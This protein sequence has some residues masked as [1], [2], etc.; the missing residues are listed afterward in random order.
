MTRRVF[1]IPRRL[2]AI[3]WC[4]RFEH[5]DGVAQPDTAGKDRT[6]TTTD[7]TTE[8]H[9]QHWGLEDDE[10]ATYNALSKN[11]DEW[12]ATSL[13]NWICEAFTHPAK[14]VNGAR[15]GPHFDNELLREIERVLRVPVGLNVRK[16]ALDVDPA[17]NT[18]KV[19]YQK[20]S[21]RDLWRLVNYLLGHGHA[22]GGKLKTYLLDAGSAY[23][24][25][26]AGGGRCYL[27]DRVPEGVEV[28]AAAAFRY[29]NGGNR[30]ASAWEAAFGI[31]PDPT[32]AYSMAVKAVEDAAIPV[33]CPND[34]SATLGKVIGQ[35][36]AGT[37]KLPHLRE[38][39]NA[40]THDVLV[41]MMRTLWVGQHDRHGGPS[42]VGVPAVT[43]EEAESA[44]MLAVTMVGWFE[45]AKVAE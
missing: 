9:W 14:V 24:V 31:N 27:T 16:Q 37:W 6:V 28:A 32:R 40:P 11:I 25:A 42:S 3:A 26:D 35:V 33:V 22:H 38:D 39:P 45:T 7:D 20:R 15:Y 1:A 18:V 41:G 12:L 44:V 21:T 29:A 13:W 8:D 5:T 30:L 17:V 23:T 34:T 19:A 2:R 10:I 36:N 43:Q 4:L